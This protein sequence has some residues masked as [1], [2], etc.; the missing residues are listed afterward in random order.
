MRYVLQIGLALSLLLAGPLAKSQT[1]HFIA[2]ADT[3]DPTIGGNDMKTYS[4]LIGNGGLA[5]TIAQY[6]G[7][8]LT[9]AGFYGPRCQ[10]AELDKLVNELS[11]GKDDVVFFYFV[12][13]G[14]NSRQN[15]YPSLIFGKATADIATIDASARNLREVYARIRAK[16]PRLTIVVGDA[17][18]KER[19]DPPAP[20]TS[21]RPI[22]V[23]PP[24]NLNPE[25]IKS[26]FRGW[27]GGVLMSSS[28]RN[29]FSHS[30][31]KG[32]WMSVSF[33]NA[34]LDQCSIT[35]KGIL[36]W[37]TLLDDVTRRTE[38]TARQ[39]R[40]AQTPQ[41]EQDL[42]PFSVVQPT[43]P[44]IVSRSF[45]STKPADAPCPSLDQF[46][47]EI[48]LAGIRE[49]MPLLRDMN[50][51]ITS[52]NA[53]AYAQSFSRF[54]RNQ[55]P[56]YESLNR[57]LFNRISDLS[58]RCQ[59]QFE[60]DTKWVKAST[61]EVNERYQIIQ[62]YAQRPNQLVQQARSDLPSI[63]R[64]LEEILERLDK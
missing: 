36:N 12:G 34:L 3:D 15:P 11:P 33:Q 49:D 17:C 25:R 60:T 62:K 44:V 43:Q 8:T 13:H 47:N 50:N 7:L 9:M 58:P 5:Q 63:I 56:F 61:D 48:A 37:K 41:F 22:D 52:D 26:L 31:P 18:N 24:T 38:A 42:T 54:Y 45:T 59:Q 16:K 35:R 27:Q 14:F 32:G 28:Q 53:S 23:M 2:F 19:T 40:Q 55:K 10:A 20:I 64:R 6:S 30:D 1:L 57:I 39:N 51:A 46:V 29:Q 21:S 4:S